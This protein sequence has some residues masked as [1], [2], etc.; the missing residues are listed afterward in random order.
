MS[1]FAP[2]FVQQ[3]APAEVEQMSESRLATTNELDRLAKVEKYLREVQPVNYKYLLPLL[4]NLKGHPYS[5]VDQFPFEPMFNR[6]MPSG[7]IWMTGRQTGKTVSL[8]ASSITRAL[9]IKDYTILLV[10]PLFEMIRRLSNNNVRP[11]IERSPIRHMFSDTTTE[12]NVLQ[13][14]FKNHSKLMFSYAF[15]DAERVRGI[16]AHSISKDELQG[17]DPSLM[18]VIDETMSASPNPFSLEAGTPKSMENLIERRWQESSQAEWVVKCQACNHYNIPAIAH[19]L[20]KMIGP[21]RAD[22]SENLPGVICAKCQRPI[23]PRLH[24]R[25]EHA[26]PERRFELA[27][28]HVP[29]IMMPMHYSNPIKWRA[30]LNKQAGMGGVSPSKFYNEVLGVSYDVGSRLISLTD[31][32]KAAVLGPNTTE[33]AGAVIERYTHRILAVDWGG[34]GQDETSFTTYAVL[35]ITPDGKI[36]CP[37]GFRSVTPHDHV[38][39]AKLALNFMAQ[40]RCSHLVHD[41]CGAGD[42]RQTFITMA[43]FPTNRII[44]IAYVRAASQG[45]MRF[46]KA[47]HIN[48]TAHYRLDKARSLV[49]TCELIKCGYLRFF[50]YDYQGEDSNGLL[51]DFLSLVEDKTESRTGS[52]SYTIIRDQQ[53]AT[54]DDFAQA[55]NIGTMALFHMTERWPQMADIMSLRASQEALDAG[56]ILEGYWNTL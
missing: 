51:H 20:D 41:Y 38:G 9:V 11:F 15:L 44:P 35:G 40:F 6:V 13:R 25:Y 56:N 12:N 53:S 2:K 47:D 55:V 31:I 28:Y 39:E 46:I 50:D 36:E 42:L 23:S 8:S 49:M 43:R 30:L 34:G 24:G 1:R 5:L 7:Q 16:A 17:F 3:P 48:P 21:A 45:M 54:P 37:F 14:S 19:D 4:F 22:I 18:P 29:Q 52:D 26:R 10:A 32:R 33:N 27:G